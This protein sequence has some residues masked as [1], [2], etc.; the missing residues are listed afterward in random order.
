MSS[1]PFLKPTLRMIVTTSR[2]LRELSPS[3]IDSLQA[4][5]NSRARDLDLRLGLIQVDQDGDNLIYDLAISTTEFQDFVTAQSVIERSMD[6]I[7]DVPVNEQDF[8]ADANIKTVF[9]LGGG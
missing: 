7:L 1:R 6:E 3:E 8:T 4:E 2:T 5:I 9:G